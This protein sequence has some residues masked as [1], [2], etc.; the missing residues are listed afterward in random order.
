MSDAMFKVN[1]FTRCID[2]SNKNYYVILLQ[3]GFQ[4]KKEGKDQKS[5]HSSNTPDPGHLMGK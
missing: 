3:P 1:Y 4:N 2:L 5:I